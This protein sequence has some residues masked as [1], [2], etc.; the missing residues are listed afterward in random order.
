MIKGEA[1]VEIEKRKER[2]FRNVLGRWGCGQ[3]KALPRKL[4]LA[5][6]VLKVDNLSKSSCAVH[7]IPVYLLH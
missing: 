7:P 2:D 6:Q 4:F 5:G 1:G 3:R